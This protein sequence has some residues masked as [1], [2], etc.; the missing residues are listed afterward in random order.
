VLSGRWIVK[1]LHLLDCCVETDNAAAIVVTS[2]D[3]ARDCLIRQR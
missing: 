2:A 3:R 1:L